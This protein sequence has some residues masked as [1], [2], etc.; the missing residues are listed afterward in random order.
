MPG[1]RG[2]STDVAVPLSKLTEVIVETQEDLKKSE[3]FGTIVGY[4]L[5]M[6]LAC[7]AA[8]LVQDCAVRL[9]LTPFLVTITR[10][11]SL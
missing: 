9:V 11:L 1:S 3:L 8:L 6:S 2:L 4:A 10:C 7:M 5:C